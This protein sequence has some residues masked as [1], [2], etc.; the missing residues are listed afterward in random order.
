MEER[1][2]WLKAAEA[3]MATAPAEV[4]ILPRELFRKTKAIRAA[5]TLPEFNL[6]E[7]R[8]LLA[9]RPLVAAPL[10]RRPQARKVAPRRA[11]ASDPLEP[12]KKAGLRGQT[13]NARRTAESAR[14]ASRHR[15]QGSGPCDDSNVADGMEASER[16]ETSTTA[17]GFIARSLPGLPAPR[18]WPLPRLL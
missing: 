17:A 6:L 13:A 12:R 3:V 14:P 11:R 16:T 8:P 7:P 5:S 2:C 15:G 1:C 4:P 10:R 9:L 18:E